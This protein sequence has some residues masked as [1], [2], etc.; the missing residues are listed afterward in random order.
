MTV[1]IAACC[2]E[3]EGI[4]TV[5]ASSSIGIV[6]RCAFVRTGRGSTYGRR[7]IAFIKYPLKI[8]V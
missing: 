5:I 7:I 1:S 3:F 8:N 4:G 6:S 2:T